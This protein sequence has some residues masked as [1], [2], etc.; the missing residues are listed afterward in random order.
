MPNDN[1]ASQKP[2]SRWL[3]STEWLA[4]QLGKP[5]V[6]IV[7]GSYYL[8]TQKRDAKAEYIAGHIPGAVFFD[9]N[10]TADTSTDL[11]HMLPGP[12]QFARDMGA[13]GIADTDTIVVY[14]GT[15]LY[16]APRVWW[17]FRIFGASN[18]FI[19][20]G[21]LPAWKAE[22]RP[23]EAGD[24]KRGPHEFKAVMDTSAVAMLSDVQMALNDDSV[25]VVDARS[26][27]RFSGK[28]TEPRA[29]LRSGHM[30]G[31]KNAPFTE[32]VENGRL[33]SPD[34]IAKVFAAYGVDPDKPT[35]T[36]CGSGVTAVVLALGMDALGKP[37]PRIYDGSW[38]EWGGR[39]DV[40]VEKD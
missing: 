38:S 3:R 8:T 7:D 5:G 22:G 32:I 34:K 17:T 23:T 19:L 21:G 18:V 29:G 4:G 20:D 1:T 10:A 35:I 6:S 24:V 15:G 36:T 39:P 26:A 16:S 33:A 28:E 30:P 40:E 12:D 27:G 31:A 9:I 2:A 11:P 37:L 25:Q 13:L 14:D